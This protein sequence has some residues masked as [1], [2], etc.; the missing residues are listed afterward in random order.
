MTQ[1][2][3]MDLVL[4]AKARGIADSIEDFTC[5]RCS[6]WGKY[7]FAFDFYNTNDDCLAEK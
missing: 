4:D 1:K 7:P 2:T 6:Q 5:Y 3:L